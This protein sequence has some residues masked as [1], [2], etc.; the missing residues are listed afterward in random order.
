VTVLGTVAFVSTGFLPSPF[1]KI[2]IVFQAL[3]LA[4]GSLILAR[5]GATYVSVINGLLV[6][7]L[8]IEYFPFSFLFSLLYGVLVDSAFY[9]FK[10]RVNNDVSGTRLILAL[11]IGTVITGLTSMYSTTLIGLLPINRVLYL[12]ILAVGVLSG[13]IAGYLTLIVWKRFVL[14]LKSE[15]GTSAT[16]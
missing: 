9:I 7:L 6:T 14:H 15:T 1:D 13:A 2:F 10:V 5:G 12:A 8:R 16:M 4:V 11:T 3:P